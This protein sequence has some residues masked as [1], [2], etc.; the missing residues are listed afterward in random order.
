MLIKKGSI[1]VASFKKYS[2]K[3]DGKRLWEL[4]LYLGT[5]ELT[6][7]PIRIS[8]RLDNNGR[9]FSTKKEAIKEA[10]RLEKEYEDNKSDEILRKNAVKI[11]TFEAIA[12]EWLNTRYKETVKDS[13]YLNTSNVFFKLHII[14]ALGEYI[15]SRINKE[16][17]EDVVNEWSKSFIKHRYNLVVNYTKRVFVYALKE[18][19]IDSN[20]FDLVH[21]PIVR[22]ENTVDNRESKFYDKDEVV[23]FLNSCKDYGHKADEGFWHT[24]F[25]FLVFTG[26]RSGE[27]RALNWE[28]IDFNEGLVSISKTLSVRLSE[29]TQK[30]EMYL[31]NSTKNNEDRTVTLDA[32]TLNHLKELKKKSK[33]S[34]IFP[35][36]RDGGWMHSQAA[37]NAM[38]NIIKSGNHKRIKL[39]ELRH[40]HCSLL[41]DAG[42]NIKEV[43]KRLGHKDVKITLNIYT[44]VTK[45]RQDE[46]ANKLAEYVNET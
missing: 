38:R 1:N 14:P 18:G 35:A 37:S 32:V 10:E 45:N 4:Q 19:Y 46:V 2:R 5:D 23:G 29:E 7:K 17:L 28:D 11:D 12:D 43:Q 31:S 42:V 40:T 21:V 15:I 16:V 9:R 26:V 6:G 34:L 3:K 41:F 30:T 33:E 44:H 24:F 20:P 27:A 22:T 36:L 39:H 8:R 13:T 25:H